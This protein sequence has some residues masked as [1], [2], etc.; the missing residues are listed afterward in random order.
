[1]ITQDDIDAFIEMNKEMNQRNQQKEK[2]LEYG[3]QLEEKLKWT[4]K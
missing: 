4:H 1:M 3:R 2:L